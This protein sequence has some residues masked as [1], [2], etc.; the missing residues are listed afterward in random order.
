MIVEEHG[1]GFWTGVQLPSSPLKKSQF[2][3]SC[4]FFC[5]LQNIVIGVDYKGCKRL[6]QRTEGEISMDNNFNMP[7]NNMAIEQPKKKT[8]LIIGIIA[9]V[10]ALVAIVAVV[11]ILV[12]GKK[13]ITGTWSC[14]EDGLTMQF[15]FNEDNTGS[16]SIASYSVDMTWTYEDD[17][18]TMTVDENLAGESS[19]MSCTV[20]DVTS[21]TLTLEMDGDEA[22]FN[23]VD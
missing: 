20:V 10:V 5:Y 2:C 1:M 18:V 23:R 12:L 15:V 7:Q 13:D 3:I 6:A 17:V 21:D 4:D 16:I 19:S 9:A 8:G 14:T 22:V 11:L